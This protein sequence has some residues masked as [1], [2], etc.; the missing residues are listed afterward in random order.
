MGQDIDVLVVGGGPA[1]L[2]A[3]IAARKKGFRVIVADGAKPP[4]TKACGEGLLPDAVAALGGLGVALR[5]TDGCAFR[6]IR[7]AHSLSS[8]SPPFPPS[9]L[10][11][12][13]TE[14]SH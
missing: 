8:L 10:P 1:G 11:P 6:G 5:E 12:L 14:I 4:I 9:H 2:A 3:A 7:F 13:R